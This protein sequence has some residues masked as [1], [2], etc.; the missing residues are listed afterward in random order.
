MLTNVSCVPPT[1]W[2]SCVVCVVDASSVPFF[3]SAVWLLV[4]VGL[5]CGTLVS[6]SSACKFD[7]AFYPCCFPKRRRGD[8]LIFL[9]GVTVKWSP[10]VRV[11]SCEAERLN[12][13]RH[14]D[15]RVLTRTWFSR[16]MCP[17]LIILL[18]TFMLRISGGYRLSIYQ[19]M[20]P[21]YLAFFLEKET[22]C[23]SSWFDWV[24]QKRVILCFCIHGPGMN[25]T[26]I[27]PNPFVLFEGIVT[28]PSVHYRSRH[29]CMQEW[30][31]SYNQ[32][33][34]PIF[35]DCYIE[36]WY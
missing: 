1:S 31:L 28:C 34:N 5:A 4:G 20:P 21:L 18:N 33:H 32:F 12:P 3:R 10:C 19:S 35:T 29:C 30:I 15:I 36:A 22:L 7:R 17:S 2:V 11:S 14:V 9:G 8:D 16:L 23:L 27:F 26:I 6:S 13:W 25:T 24:T